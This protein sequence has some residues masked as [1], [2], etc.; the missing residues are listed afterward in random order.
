MKDLPNDG[1]GFSGLS[2][3]SGK[4]NPSDSNKSGTEPQQ[5]VADGS[6]A[7]EEPVA[8]ARVQSQTA[9]PKWRGII[10]AAMLCLAG[11]G[12]ITTLMQHPGNNHT[13]TASQAASAAFEGQ[14]AADAT[15]A[16]GDEAAAD[17]AQAAADAAAAAANAA[18]SVTAAQMTQ[19]AAED[20]KSEQVPGVGID[21]VLNTPQIRYCVCE[22]IRL[23]AAEKVVDSYD[24]ESVDRFNVMIGDYNRRCGSFRYRAGSLEA[25]QSEAFANRDQL[26][27][28]GRSRFPLY[29]HTT[30]PPPESQAIES[31]PDDSPED[32]DD[33]QPGAQSVDQ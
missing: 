2:G 31:T 15:T 6:G 29:N 33:E 30:E 27:E 14:S 4:R 5:F 25:V 16:A 22:K 23:D 12:V 8:A 11:F 24:G 3:L 28:E 9:A 7:S 20:T 19:G 26:E 17:A 13:G 21:Q 1:K 32:S 10:V 18:N